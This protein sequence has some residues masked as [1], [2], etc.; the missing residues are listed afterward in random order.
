MAA[1][2]AGDG[3]IGYADESQVGDLGVAA[4]KVGS[5]YN[6]PSAE[7]AAKVLAH[8]PKVSGRGANDMAIEVDRTTTESGAYPLSLTSYLIACPTYDSAS[9]ADL[10]KGFLSYVVSERG[11]AGR[12]GPGRLGPAGVQP[13]AGG[14]QD[15]RPDLG[16]VVITEASIV[17]VRRTGFPV[18]R[19]LAFC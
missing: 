8:S 2:K 13:P 6:A 7:G 19:T 15:R 14:G 12:R 18:R 10:V 11:P 4:I 16:Q 5:E 9:D 1:V 3:T 17:G